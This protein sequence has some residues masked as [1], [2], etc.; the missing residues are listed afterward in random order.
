MDDFIKEVI[1]ES[2]EE[3]LSSGK[4]KLHQYIESD[5]NEGGY[6]YNKGVNL[7][8][9]LIIQKEDG[10]IEEIG[11]SVSRLDID[12]LMDSIFDGFQ[13]AKVEEIDK[14]YH[15]L[16]SKDQEL[17]FR[18]QNLH[19]LLRKLEDDVEAVKTKIDG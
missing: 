2:L 8:S 14:L 3:L 5:R 1:I 9:K 10:R 19:I 17:D 11:L 7:I 4:I 12:I 6:Y 16:K 15:E 13:P 18:M